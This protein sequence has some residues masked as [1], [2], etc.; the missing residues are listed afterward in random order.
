M[1]RS[2]RAKSAVS[3]V[4]QDSMFPMMMMK[5]KAR[6]MVKDKYKEKYK[7]GKNKWFFQKL[8]F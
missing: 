6:N 5:K 3:V 8:R 1:R 4:S 7:S 2:T